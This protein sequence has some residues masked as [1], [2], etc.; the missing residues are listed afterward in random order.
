MLSRF[1][2][3]P[4]NN[5]FFLFG[6]RQ[7]GKTT[8]IQGYLRGRR[9]WTV[10]LL[11]R[12][13]YLRYLTQPNLF[14]L[15]ADKLIKESSPEI[16]FVDEVQKIP[17]LLDEIQRLIQERKARFILTGSSARKLKRGGANL[18]GGR[19]VERNLFPLT[20][21]ELSGRYEL[22]DILRFGALPSIILNESA[23]ARTDLLNAYVSI[24]LAEEIQQE[25]LVRNLP[26]FVAF[27]EVAA[28]QSGEILNFARVGREAG[29]HGRTVQSY[30]QI[31]EDTLIGIR[32]PPYTRSARRR[33]SNSPKFYLFDIGLIN[34]LEHQL[35]SEPD[36]NR[37]GRLFE[38]FIVLETHRL[39]RYLSSDGRIFFWRTKDGQ[40]VDLLIEHKGKLIAA[41]EIKS[42]TKVSMEDL[43][44]LK[45]FN[46]DYPGV[47]R[48]VAARVPQAYDLHDISVLPWE[49][50]L[51]RL[52]EWLEA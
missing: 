13:V 9:A 17:E 27:L 48:F 43:A 21:G 18:L 6:P 52:L 24:Y 29:L 38:H 15:E 4:E 16:I 33:L 46:Q 35:R 37:F 51:Q 50:Y 26:G 25:A 32:L 23:E 20:Y 5:N 36:V 42:S 31:L 10:N 19:A 7:T 41:V 14:Y 40:E 3:I 28:Q 12:A 45:A 22:Q 2:N 1:C 39:V 11:D 49:Q 44:A 34:A 47:P 30:Y 8:L